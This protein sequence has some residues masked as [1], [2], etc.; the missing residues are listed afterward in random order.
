MRL[1]YNID[2]IEDKSVKVNIKKAI[3][4]LENSYFTNVENSSFF[5]NPFE[6]KV[7]DDIARINK[8]PLE[9]IA[10]NENCERKIFV[11]CPYSSYINTKD[12]F[13]SFEFN[14]VNLRHPDILGS[15]LNLGIE[16][17]DIGD[18]YVGNDICEFV[19]LN[20][21]R[22][23][24]KFNLNKIKNERVSLNFK[25][26]NTIKV[27]DIEYEFKKGFVSSLRLDNVVSELVH[28]SRSKA[29]TMIDRKLVK[30]NYQ[31][32]ENPSKIIE[33]NSLISIRKVGRFFFDEV[34]G[35]SKKGNYHIKYRKYK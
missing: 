15:L 17:N 34:S 5:L 20:K 16:R 30:V 35:L 10:A 22:D 7:I 26:D 24:I 13:T 1:E 12:Y 14:H 32:I 31:I 18:I 25:L 9:F 23:F 19:V 6:R 4:I 33:E 3:S 27:E 11:A 28:L 2:F 29:K 21:D 8:I